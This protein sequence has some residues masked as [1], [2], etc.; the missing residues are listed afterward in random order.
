MPCSYNRLPFLSNVDDEKALS[1]AIQ[2]L[3]N[4]MRFMKDEIAFLNR[5][6]ARHKSSN[7]ELFILASN[8]TLG[9]V[10]YWS[11]IQIGLLIAVVGFQITYL[12]GIFEKKRMI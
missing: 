2:S 8:S 7:Y 10:F 11:M 1:T 9:R 3:S 5:R 6:V 4:D 12:R